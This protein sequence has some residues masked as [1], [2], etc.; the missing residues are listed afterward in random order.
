MRNTPCCDQPGTMP[1]G[2]AAMSWT[3]GGVN[4]IHCQHCKTM[5]GP[6]TNVEA[7]TADMPSMARTRIVS[8]VD[9]GHEHWVC[10]LDDGTTVGVPVRCDS[11][12]KGDVLTLFGLGVDR[13]V[14]AIMSGGEVL[15]DTYDELAEGAEH[16]RNRAQDAERILHDIDSRYG[17]LLG[18]LDAVVRGV[19]GVRRQLGNLRRAVASPA[20]PEGQDG[21]QPP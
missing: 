19:G 12:K 3:P 5:Y 1:D 17:P 13:P 9:R 8:S 7:G 14:R 4:T 18:G 10:H 16:W 2:S 15:F 20:R 6:V 21:P 11:P